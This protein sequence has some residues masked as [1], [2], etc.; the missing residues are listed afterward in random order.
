MALSSARG[1]TTLG[2]RRQADASP[3][4]APEVSRRLPK[5]GP[6]GLGRRRPNGHR[7]L[8]TMAFLLPALLFYTVYYLYAFGFL[9]SVSH[10][11]VSLTFVQPIEVGW[12]NFRL[13]LTDPLF[14]RSVLN[15]LLF[16]GVSI[17]AGLTVGFLLSMMIATGVRGRRILY[18][19]FLLPS[20]IPLSL[21]ATVFG[22]MLEQQDGALNTLLRAVGLGALQQNWLGETGPGYAAVFILLVFLV[23][24]PIMY[25]TSD[26]TALNLSVVES[27]VLDGAGAWQIFR[28]MLF[29][30]LRNTHKTVILAGLLGSFRAFDVI[31]FSTAGQP[32]G[33]TS[34]TGTYIYSTAL[35]Q[36]RVGYAAAAA[37]LVLVMAL[38][39][40]IV[41]L[42]FTRRSR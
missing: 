6:K 29:P 15:T 35:G 23:G 17:L 1:T 31:Y 10:Q 24:L 19:I 22:Q 40:S 5:S 28:L 32:G 36:S 39:I 14:Q 21:F 8:V 41:N 37:V 27:A 42:L 30:M 26:V 33:R 25:Y 4:G 3:P 7:A 9:A 11:R 38:L 34:I 2:A 16:A 13:V 20:L 12:S 18:G